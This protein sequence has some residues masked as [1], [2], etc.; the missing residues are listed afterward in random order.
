MSKLVDF[1]GIAVFRRGTWNG[2]KYGDEAPHKLAESFEYFRKPDPQTGE[3]FYEP[4]VS[5]NHDE[6]PHLA[7]FQFG[8][9]S[10][11]HVDDK[12]LLQLDANE[13]PEEIGELVRSGKLRK[14]SLEFAEPQRDASGNLIGGMVGPDGKIYDGPVIKC[15]T[16]LGSEA[17]GVKGLP[18]LPDPVPSRKL[19]DNTVKRFAASGLKLAR[20][21]ESPAM[22]RQATIQA[23]QTAGVDCSTLT[24]AVP[25][26]FLAAI[27]AAFQKINAATP[28]PDDTTQLNDANGGVATMPSGGAA[29]AGTPAGSATAPSQVLVKFRQQYPGVLEA[30]TGELGGTIQSLQ[31]KA[32]DVSRVQAVVIDGHKDTCIQAF[33]DRMNASGQITEAE[34]PGLKRMLSVLDHSTVKKFADATLAFK[35]RTAGSGTQLEEALAEMERARPVIRKFGHKTPQTRTVEG[36]AKGAL[37]QANRE[38]LLKGAGVKAPA[39]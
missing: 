2:Q 15:L 1:P 22:D 36:G 29:P 27:L 19:S 12:G 18:D 35:G 6:Y 14:P 11:V 39:K 10:A 24:D 33:F 25:D 30:L 34:V 16:F 21:M 26:E 13:V 5:I 31:A 17:P 4:Y 9:L 8:L 7:G 28:A 3:P 20:L 23:L 37:S 32:K 38:K